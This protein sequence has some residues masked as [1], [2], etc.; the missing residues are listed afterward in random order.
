MLIARAVY[1][2][3]NYHAQVVYDESGRADVEIKIY[4]ATTS[5]KGIRVQE[6]QM[7]FEATG[8]HLQ[9]LDTIEIHNETDPMKTF[10]NPEGNFRFSKAPGILSLPQMRIT[11]AGSS[12]PVVQSPLES[13]DGRSYY[14]L[15]PL[16]PGET[17]IDIFQ[18]MP[19]ENRNYDYV[20]KFYCPVPSIEIGVIPM[21]ME[22]SGAGLAKIRTDPQK[23]VAV[24]RSG[25]VDA[26]TEVKW[27]FSGGTPV[28]ERAPSVSEAESNIRSLPNAVQRSALVV[29]P[30][31]LMGFV[32]VLWYAF[33]RT[34][35]E[36]PGSSGAR[37]PR[38]KGGR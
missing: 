29:G 22:L 35:E 21:D 11:A 32:L 14:S 16:R 4:E 12:L 15:Y 19:Y 20:K 2:N 7:V 9:S 28:E 27:T 18:I 33:H 3:A 13:P 6:Y 37:K 8:N 25:P 38:L 36:I 31:L 10:M 24:Y 34:G 23:N 1:Q 30:L 5:M 17:T 26:G